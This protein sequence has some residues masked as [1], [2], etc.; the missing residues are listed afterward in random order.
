[1][2]PQLRIRKVLY[3]LAVLLIAGFAL[4]TLIFVMPAAASRQNVQ[5]TT[6]TWLDGPSGEIAVDQEMTVTVRISDVVGLYGVEFSLN[7]TPTQLQVLDADLGAPGVQIAAAECPQPDF[8]VQNVVSNTAGTIEYAVTHLN[9]T[10]PFSGDCDVAHIRFRAQQTTPTMVTF[11]ELIL[12]DKDF[13]QIPS[14]VIDIR[15][16]ESGKRYV[17]LPTILKSQPGR[18]VTAR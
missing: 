6:I 4:A 17:Y 9:P 16:G 7:F 2:K 10:S 13:G 3:L 12:S 11:V 14:E 15:I 18:R 1:M 8:T 5:E